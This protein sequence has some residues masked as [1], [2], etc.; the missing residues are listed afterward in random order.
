MI[1]TKGQASLY[2]ALR[3]LDLE[4][5]LISYEQ[6]FY[7]S[8]NIPGTAL[9]FTKEWSVVPPY[10][11]HCIIRSNIIYERNVFISIVRTDE[12]FDVQTVLT[13]GDRPGSGCFR[14]SCRLYGDHR[15]RKTAEG[16]RHQGKGYLLRD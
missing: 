10:V 9:F 5:F 16:E 14:N 3:P 11:I 7:K 2:K 13:A 15:Y 1:W 6:I 12:P 8:R 4:T